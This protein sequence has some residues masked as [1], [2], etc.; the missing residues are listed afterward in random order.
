MIFIYVYHELFQ[1]SIE[2]FLSNCI[3]C[4]GSQCFK[5]LRKFEFRTIEAER[6]R[7][8]S[9]RKKHDHIRQSIRYLDFC[10]VV[11]V[12][13]VSIVVMYHVVSS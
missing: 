10:V 2:Y 1:I 9:E 8:E 7:I 13:V 4:V 6:Y 5:S 3:S 11:V 12:V